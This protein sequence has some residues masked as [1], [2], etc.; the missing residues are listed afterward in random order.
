LAK[1]ADGSGSEETL[2]P[3]QGSAVVSS[4]WSPDGKFLVYWLAAGSGKLELWLLPL[5]GERKPRPLLANQFDEINAVFS[6]DGKYLAY[7]PNESGHYEVYVIPF[8]QGSGKWQISTGGGNFPVW[9]RNGKELFYRYRGDIMG[10]DVTAQPV[11]KA[12]APRVI[13]PAKAIANLSNG[14][15]NFDVSPDGQRFLIHQ[16][17]SEAGQT[18]Q[19]NDV[20]NWSEK[21]RRLTPASKQ[22]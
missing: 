6:R 22:P 20:L 19:I 21:L 1:P 10:V 9:A 15:D 12:S 3:A 14:L 8:G 13:V 18:L 17:S 4:S 11:F 5:V 2:L 16:Q 7:A